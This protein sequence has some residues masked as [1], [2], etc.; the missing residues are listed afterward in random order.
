MGTEGALGQGLVDRW[1]EGTTQAGRCGDIAQP[2]GALGERTACLEV[3]AQSW[4]CGQ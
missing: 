3:D 4:G 2:A 1:T